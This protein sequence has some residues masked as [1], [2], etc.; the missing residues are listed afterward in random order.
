MV[1]M[2]VVISVVALFAT[3]VVPNIVS[4]H[5]SMQE[6][7]FVNSLQRVAADAR[8][9]AISQNATMRLSMSG[10]RLSVV[11][12]SGSAQKGNEI[13]GVDLIEGAKGTKFQLNGQE[14]SSDWAVRFFPDGTADEGGVE[15]TIGESSYALNVTPR[16]AVNLTDQLID[17]NALRWDAGP[18]ETR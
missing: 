16:G 2:S 17:A 18:Y 4:S 7:L 3:F 12:D 5:K 13:S 9:A 15:I 1:E 8:E 10:N 11:P 6:R 14:M